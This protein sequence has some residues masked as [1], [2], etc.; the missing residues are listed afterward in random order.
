MMQANGFRQVG[1]RKVML[2][3]RPIGVA[4][5]FDAEVRLRRKTINYRLGV[6]LTHQSV[7]KLR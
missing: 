3:L 2:L 4:V 7:S 6:R 1:N 5:D